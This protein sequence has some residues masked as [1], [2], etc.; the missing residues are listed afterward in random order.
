MANDYSQQDYV[1]TEQDKKSSMT[2][3]LMQIGQDISSLMSNSNAVC[4]NLITLKNQTDENDSRMN[5]VDNIIADLL[6]R[7]S[8][9]EDHLYRDK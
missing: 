4:T 5:T 8:G 1:K 7:I 9:I 6:A 2:D 3:V